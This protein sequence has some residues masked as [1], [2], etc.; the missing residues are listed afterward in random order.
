MNK[1]DLS[2]TDICDRFITPALRQAGWLQERILREHSFTDGRIIVRGRL[3]SRG[4]RKRA[5]YLLVHEGVPLA[6]IEAKDNSQ[7][8]GAGM[9]QALAY[10]DALGVPHLPFVFSSNGDGFLFHDRTGQA[11]TVESVLALEH[12]PRPEELW[13]RYCR[14]RGFTAEQEKVALQ[15]YY[16]GG[17]RKEPR[18]YQVNAIQATVEAIARGQQRILLVMATG[19]G[20]TFTAFQ[21]IWR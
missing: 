13:Q 3:V 8:L 9:Q 20:K 19:T 11:D 21:I 7:A 10:S 1:R 12:F 2:E 6:V 14:W 16:D 17:S 15:P 18:Y 4:R 5:D